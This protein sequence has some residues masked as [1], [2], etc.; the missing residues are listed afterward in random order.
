MQTTK[1]L[2]CMLF[3]NTVSWSCN[4]NKEILLFSSFNS[5]FSFGNTV[6]TSYSSPKYII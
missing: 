4:L 5:L 1:T 3:L 6:N 2:K